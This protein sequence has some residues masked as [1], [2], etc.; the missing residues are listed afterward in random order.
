MLKIVW[1][2]FFIIGMAMAGAGATVGLVKWIS[3]AGFFN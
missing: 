1:Y 3:A 2:I